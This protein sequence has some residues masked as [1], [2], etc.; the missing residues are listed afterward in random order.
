MAA[1][2]T[3]EISAEVVRIDAATYLAL[4]NPQRIKE[5]I[6][7]KLSDRCYRPKLE[8]LSTDWVS[9]VA[10]P[11]FKI[12]R[13]QR[14]GGEIDSFCS[15]GTGSGLDVLSAIEV[16]GAT[17]VGLTDV[18]EEVV[19]TAVENVAGNHK[20]DS[21]VTIEAGHG[22]LLEPLRHYGSRYAVI[23]ENLPNVR[24]TTREEV[25]AE[26][27]SSTY[28]GPRDEFLPEFVKGQMLDL[29]Y[30]ALMQARELLIPGGV[31]LAC[32]GARVPLAVLYSLGEL[33]GFRSTPLTYSWKLQEAARELVPGYLESQRNGFG[34]FY[35]YRPEVLRRA[36]A[37][38]PLA[39][40]G[41]RALE[42]ERSVLPYRL[43][44][45]AAQAVLD[46]GEPLG[47]TVAFVKSELK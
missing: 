37:D 32:L 12:Y 29:H 43:D 10:V 16:L 31:M 42:I 9:R 34:P 30:L 23:Y 36:F 41:A 8:D 2:N 47:H 38:I 15:I 35:F 24:L 44:A 4:K 6:V 45:A 13:H 25:A 17:R 1:T 22:D 11:G 18:H 20:A 40:S 14:G 33:A 5:E 7:L 46:N 27:N 26:R 3:A 21:P 28:V 19:A 39:E